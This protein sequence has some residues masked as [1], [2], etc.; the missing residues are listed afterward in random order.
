MSLLL[1]AFRFVMLPGH[2]YYL[3]ISRSAANKA[4]KCLSSLKPHTH[5]YI[6]VNY[7]FGQCEISGN[8]LFVAVVVVANAAGAVLLVFIVIGYISGGCCVVMSFRLFAL[9]SK[10]YQQN[11]IA[12]FT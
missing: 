7:T 4:L 11:A 8:L 1:N 5:C 10:I 12:T 2:M 9:L 3:L 6:T